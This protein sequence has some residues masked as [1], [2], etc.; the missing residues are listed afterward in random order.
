LILDPLY[1]DSLNTT[2]LSLMKKL[3]PTFIITTD[4]AGN[5]MLNGDNWSDYIDDYREAIRQ[6]SETGAEIFVANQPDIT[7]MD[8]YEW[9]DSPSYLAY[10]RGRIEAMNADIKTIVEDDYG[11]HV[12]DFYGAMQE[13][14]KEIVV[15]TGG[16]DVMLN[17]D[18]GGGIFSLDGLHYTSVGYALLANLFIEKINETYHCRYPEVDVAEVLAKE[19]YS[20]LTISCKRDS[21]SSETLCENLK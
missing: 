18:I 21:H 20:P 5:N 7:T 15:R 4:L 11:G 10:L 13:W 3:S 14:K 8:D 17:M 1:K 16:R 2:Q 9:Y 12:V 6:M 19:P